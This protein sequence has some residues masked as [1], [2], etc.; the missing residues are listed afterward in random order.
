MYWLITLFLL[1]YLAVGI[2]TLIQALK[3]RAKPAAAILAGAVWPLFWLI[4]KQEQEKRLGRRPGG[5]LP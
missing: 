5:Y 2:Y 1:L 3:M 4:G